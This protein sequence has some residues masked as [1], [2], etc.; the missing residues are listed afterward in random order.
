MERETSSQRD[1]KQQ[2]HSDGLSNRQINKNTL[3]K[4]SVRFPERQIEL[5]GED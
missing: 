4:K 3:V 2:T 1:M 5:Y